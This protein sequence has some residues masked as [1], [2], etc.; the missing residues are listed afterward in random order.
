M[1]IV[2]E[3]LPLWVGWGLGSFKDFYYWLHTFPASVT[4]FPLFLGTIPPP[5]LPP[6]LMS[7]RHFPKNVFRVPRMQ[8]SSHCMAVQHP[9]KCTT[10]HYCMQKKLSCSKLELECFFNSAVWFDPT[11]YM[12]TVRTSNCCRNASRVCCI[13]SKSFSTHGGYFSHFNC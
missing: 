7:W 10:T 1:E 9:L 6:P 13:L 11:M 8:L 3:V 4:R 5:K 2:A 12:Y